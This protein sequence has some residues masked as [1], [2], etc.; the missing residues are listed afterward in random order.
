MHYKIRDFLQAM[1]H[2]D[3]NFT[4][5]YEEKATEKVCQV[6]FDLLDEYIKTHTHKKQKSVKLV[7]EFIEG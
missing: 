1:L 7:N 3:F 2:F 6:C 5:D 4:N